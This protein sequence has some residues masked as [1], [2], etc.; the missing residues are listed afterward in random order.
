MLFVNG[1]PLVIMEA[2]AP[3]LLWRSDAINQLRR[4]QEAAPEWHGAGA[5]LFFDYNVLC[6][7]HCG[8]DAVYATVGAP[9]NACFGW[10][11][12][13]PYSDE[14][15]RRRFGVEPECQ[16]QLIVEAARFRGFRAFWC[17]CGGHVTRSPRAA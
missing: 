4:Y 7:A 2:K 15:V 6:V 14:E 8:A 1:I 9:E 3:S 17:R 13:L 5:P 16:A 12:V 11:S 10:K